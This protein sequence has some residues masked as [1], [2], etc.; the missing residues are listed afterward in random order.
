MS[1]DHAHPLLA[2]VLPTLVWM[3]LLIATFWPFSWERLR[4]RLPFVLTVGSVA[5]DFAAT[6]MPKAFPGIFESLL[7]HSIYAQRFDT[8]WQWINRW[9]IATGT[10]FEWSYSVGAVLALINL[11][12]RRAVL[13][14]VLAL[15]A[16]AIIYGM[17]ILLSRLH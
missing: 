16:A 15:T 5:L 11:A 9:E 13:L 1:F 14:N 10:V 3:A 8:D 4:D 17:N 12:R 6:T 2:F 7:G